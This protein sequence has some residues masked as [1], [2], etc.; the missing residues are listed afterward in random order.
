MRSPDQLAV[1]IPVYNESWEVAARTVAAV[2]AAFAGQGGSPRVVVVDDGSRAEF[3]LEKLSGRDDCILVRH[4][5]NRG[6]GAALKTGV[7]ATD[8]PYIAIIDADGTYPVDQLPVLWGMM[9]YQDMVVG[10]R[11]GEVSQIPLLRR[12]PKWC[13]NR[14]A[15]YMA[16][17]PI[18]DLNSGM[19]IFSRELCYYLWG[20]FP[21]GFS[22]TSTIT[23]GALLGGFR[24]RN[25]PINYF[26]R[27]G[28]SSIH[29]IK[30]TIRFFNIVARLGLLFTPM[31]FFLPLAIFLGTAGF[32]KGVLDYRHQGSLGNLSVTLMIAGLQVLLMGYLAD[33]IV[34]SRALG[35]RGP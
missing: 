20:L 17:R 14:F 28:S 15:S 23:M 5:L 32:A 30:D 29:P 24:V 1:V 18:P 11:T 22:F 16:R 26:K 6:Y 7:L 25:Q 33:L 21:N 8:A 10:V 9:D 35:R 31:R 27:I 19:R 34:H 2:H 4:E 12:M 13:L 3:Q